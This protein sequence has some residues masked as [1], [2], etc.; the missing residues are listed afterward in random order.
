V[1]IPNKKIRPQRNTG[2]VLVLSR[3]GS[4]QYTDA[5]VFPLP[6]NLLSSPTKNI[7]S[8]LF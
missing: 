8:P 1:L 4:K 6:L 3:N 5:M 2:L 7:I